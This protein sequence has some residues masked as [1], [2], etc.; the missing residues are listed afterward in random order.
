[1]TGALAAHEDGGLEVHRHVLLEREVG[2]DVAGDEVFRSSMT[3]QAE[4]F[5]RAVRGGT[6]EGAGGEDA[7]AALTVAEWTSQALAA[8]APATRSSWLAAPLRMRET[9]VS[10]GIALIPRAEAASSVSQGSFYNFSFVASAPEPG[11]LGVV[12][13]GGMLMLARRRRRPARR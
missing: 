6:R 3:L 12:A 7:V 11:T 8:G 9:A 10:S 1:M 4:G 2:G 5:A 13:A